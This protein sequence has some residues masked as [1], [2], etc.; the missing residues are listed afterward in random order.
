MV[1]ES[2]RAGRL[3]IVD[4]VC[5]VG[6][7]LPFGFLMCGVNPVAPFYTRVKVKF[8]IKLSRHVLKIRGLLDNQ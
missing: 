5:M 6:M 4:G 2:S 3:L 7:E 1:L 8:D